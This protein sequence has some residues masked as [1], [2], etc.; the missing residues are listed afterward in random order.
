MLLTHPKVDPGAIGLSKTSDGKPKV[1]DIIDCSGS[2]DVAMGAL[3]TPDSVCVDGTTKL[4]ILGLSGRV[5]TLNP[6][7]KNPSGKFRLG[8]KVIISSLNL[9]VMR[10][11]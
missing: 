8:I 5:L 10:N 6:S 3:V 7:W 2:G 1:I 11:V 4:S 9:R